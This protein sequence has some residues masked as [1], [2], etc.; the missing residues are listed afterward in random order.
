MLDH[1]GPRQ[2]LLSGYWNML[3][4]AR[5]TARGPLRSAR[6]SGWL[7]APINNNQAPH[8]NCWPKCQYWWPSPWVRTCSLG[9]WRGPLAPA[10]AMDRP[11]QSNSRDFGQQ[12]V[13]RAYSL[14]ARARK[15]WRVP[16]LMLSGWGPG[17]ER[18]ELS[19]LV[20]WW[21]WTQWCHWVRHGSRYLATINF[22]NEKIVKHKV[23]TSSDHHSSVKLSNPS[24]HVAQ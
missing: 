23:N 11:D 9:W 6:V 18:W 10:S 2:S 12:S 19:C 24:A 4:A 3:A 8:I 20:P 14:C 17:E 22:Q 7:S 15:G 21:V 13:R 1:Q 16:T 5:I